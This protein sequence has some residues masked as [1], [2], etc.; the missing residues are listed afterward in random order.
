[1]S[2]Q[3]PEASATAQ[4]TAQLTGVGPPT[5]AA[6]GGQYYPPHLQF[7]TPQN[8]T[9]PGYQ[10]T[11]QYP[12]TPQTPTENQSQTPQWAKS[13]IEDIKSIKLSVAKMD[14]IE[15]F[16]NKLNMKVEWLEQNVKS[17]EA[18]TKEIESSSQ[19]MNNELEDTRQKIKSTD[20]EIKNINKHHKE[21]EEK[22]QNIKLQADENE[23]KTNDLEARSMRENVLFYGC[24]EVLNE[25]C[26]GTVK[27]IISEKLRIVENITLDRVHRLGKPS[28]GK[29]RPIV[30]KFHYY[31]QRE[32]VRTTA[33]TKTNDLKSTGL[34]IGIQQTKAEAGKEH[35][36]QP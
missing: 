12:V 24:P 18:R 11:P 31:Q 2:N 1:M 23:Q 19:F 35:S 32:L 13:L 30:A 28:N 16:L 3:S 22:I 33:I 5:Q 21:L 17:I 27:S 8:Y 9:Y 36:I 26:E 14:E 34:G 20:T 25:N 10:S 4:L 15:K 7:M 6:Y 29:C